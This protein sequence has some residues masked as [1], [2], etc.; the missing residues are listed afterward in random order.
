M[1]HDI[2]DLWRLDAV[3]LR[4]L[5]ATRAV[6]CREATEA[7]LA[8]MEAVNGR[9]NA[10]VLPLPE[11]AR[12]A[13]DAADAALRRGEAP[14]LLHGIPVTTK[15]NVDQT[16]CPTDNGVVADKALI[17]TED[18]PVVANLRRAGAIIVG[19]TNTPTY[20]MRWFTDGALHGL[21]LNPWSREHTPGGSS[22]GAGA[23]VASGIGAI[24]HGNDIAGSV[25]YP[26]FCCGV[27]G[28][29]PTMGRIPALNKTALGPRPISGQLMAVQGPIARR[30]RDVRLAFA[31]MAVSDPRDPKSLDMP[32]EGPPLARPIRVALA[33]DPGGRGIDARL[34]AAIRRAGRWLEEAG[35]SVEEAEPPHMAEVLD[36]WPRLAMADTIAAL[37]PLI[38]RNGDDAVRR[39]FDLQR[40]NWPEA[41]PRD[42]LKALAEREMLLSRWQVFLAGCP[43]I[44]MP[45]STELPF[46]HGFD[47]RD[48][49][50]TATLLNAQR[51]QMAVSC[52]GLPAVSVP[53][54]LID[55]LPTGIQIVATRFRE[56]LCLE[57]AEIVEARA[58]MPT[59]IDPRF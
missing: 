26:A 57:A 2:H 35:Y 23:A 37:Q 25:R 8:R 22:G 32:L 51:A 50:T 16:G 17:A 29:K 14:G 33:V 44:V 31:A 10:V 15:A 45:V 55:G 7:T 9:L 4:R 49:E 21:T 59:P 42:C 34:A 46:P 18:N 38:D 28:L 43:L 40:A 48:A 52:L 19:R 13:A 24:A 39:V 47:T 5:I 56:D 36:L 1:A 11:E 27:A 6:S 20:S 30:V 53:T 3:E 12:A 41:D 58:P 54:G